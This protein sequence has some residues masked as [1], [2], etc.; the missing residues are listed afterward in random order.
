M[1]AIS[2]VLLLLALASVCGGTV[3]GLE[4]TRGGWVYIT[5]AELHISVEPSSDCK[6]E[7]VMNEPMTQRVGRLSPQVRTL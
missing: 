5:E 4:V 7:V 6:V 3:A 1:A 2:V